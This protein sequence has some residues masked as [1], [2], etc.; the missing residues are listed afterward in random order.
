[1]LFMNGKRQ[2]VDSQKDMDQSKIFTKNFTK[3][4]QTA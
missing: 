1:M 4:T 3:R 2:P